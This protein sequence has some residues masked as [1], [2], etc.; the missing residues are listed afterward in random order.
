MLWKGLCEECKSSDTALFLAKKQLFIGE[1]H[2]NKL[3]NAY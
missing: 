2:K 3:E 1:N